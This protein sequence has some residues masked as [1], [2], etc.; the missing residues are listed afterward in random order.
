MYRVVW[1][2]GGGKVPRLRA[3]AQ[4]SLVFSSS[5]GAGAAG[6]GEGRDDPATS[7]SVHTAA[8]RDGHVQPKREFLPLGQGQRGSWGTRGQ[9][10]AEGAV[11]WQ[12]KWPLQMSVP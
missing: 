3:H 4:R 9:G 1:D 6:G 10:R 11:L 12:V 8:A 5:A 7:V 2:L